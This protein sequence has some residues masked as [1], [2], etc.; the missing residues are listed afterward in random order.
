MFVAIYIVGFNGSSAFFI[1]CFV[2]NLQPM[3]SF[4]KLTAIAF[5]S[6]VLNLSVFHCS[7]FEVE[8]LLLLLSLLKKLYMLHGSETA[9]LY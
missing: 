7:V 2:C 8:P 1:V 3:Q 9:K 4:V 6:F 5:F